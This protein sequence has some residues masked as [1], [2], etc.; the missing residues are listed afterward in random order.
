[1]NDGGPAA[2]SPAKWLTRE[3]DGAAREFYRRLSDAG[4]V[5][6][7]RCERCARTSFPPRERCPACGASQTWVE[8]PREGRLYAFTTQETAVR[9][10]EPAVL[11]LV[12][13]GEAL[14]PGIVEAAYEEL[15]IGQEVRVEP[16][17]EPETGLTLLEF[18]PTA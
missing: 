1:V 11:A 17:S 8:L 9:F 5:A 15:R 6:T 12:E 14:V 16:R 7:T 2:P 13:L 3:M 4:Q 10:R 18:R